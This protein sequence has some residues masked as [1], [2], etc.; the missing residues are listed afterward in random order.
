MKPF[1]SSLLAV[2]TQTY[3]LAPKITAKRKFIKRISLEIT[4]RD[5]SRIEQGKPD[6]TSTLLPSNPILT[7][8]NIKPYHDE[9]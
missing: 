3:E 5:Q 7:L 6:Q 1:R 4:Q 2:K 8:Y 9:C